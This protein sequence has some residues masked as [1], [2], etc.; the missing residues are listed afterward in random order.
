MLEIISFIQQPGYLDPFF[1]F[2]KNHV[3]AEVLVLSIFSYLLKVYRNRYK[4]N[5]LDIQ[6]LYFKQL[7]RPTL[8]VSVSLGTGITQGRCNG[9]DLGSIAVSMLVYL[10]ILTILQQLEYFRPFVLSSNGGLRWGL[11]SRQGRESP[12]A[13][14][15]AQT[16]G[17]QL[18]QCWYIWIF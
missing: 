3:D 8:G 12:R 17:L 6:T 9:L 4:F 15:T 2:Y 14:V 5:N 18:Y 7:Q 11:A 10:D 16:Q 13:D 1:H